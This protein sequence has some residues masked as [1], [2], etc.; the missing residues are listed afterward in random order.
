MDKEL[1]DLSANIINQHLQSIFE[2]LP[3]SII[4]TNIDGKIEYV[5]LQFSNLTGYTFEESIG[6]NPR[7]LKSKNTSKKVYTNLWETILSGKS[8]KGEIQNIKKHG[9]GYWVKVE[10]IP[11]KDKEGKITH[12]FSIEEDITDFVEHK[13]ELESKAYFDDLTGLANRTL[14]LDRIEQVL[15]K[16]SRNETNMVL[17]FIDLDKFKEVNDI[18]GHEAGDALLLE[19]AYRFTACVRNS[20]TVARLGGDEFLIILP[21]LK[22]VKVASTVAQRILNAFHKPFVFSNETKQISPSIG[23]ALY[24]DDGQD[25]ETLLKNSDA[26]MY[27]AKAKGRNN[28]QFFTEEMNREVILRQGLEKYFKQALESQEIGACY[29]PVV[30]S[31]SKKI[32]G[33]E[34]FPYWENP[35]FGRLP[36][37]RILQLADDTG[38]IMPL[39]ESIFNIACQKIQ[40]LRDIIGKTLIIYLDVS[41]QKLITD[42]KFIST[43]TKILAQ[44]KIDMDNL[45]LGFNVSLFEEVMGKNMM[46]IVENVSKEGIKC[47]IYNFGLNSFV[48]ENINMKV[49][50]CLRLHSNIFKESIINIEYEAL[51]PAIILFA[52]KLGL[53]VIVKDVNTA[54]QHEILRGYGCDFIQGLYISNPLNDKD[55]EAFLEIQK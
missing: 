28:F 8:W 15:V 21:E 52:Q 26:A 43:F 17:M 42:K 36:S 31:W 47:S 24:P 49:F 29:Q 14:A 23:L 33:V 13:K 41:F 6:K 5:N 25:S 20:D 12:F 54:Q 16:A 10:I 53:L 51:M 37:E 50:K 19:A 39:I 27:R 35:E 7:F 22:G 40:L 9:E 55:F 3:Y 46:N 4:L 45:Y 1:T 11:L 34:I 38:L 32:I 44:Y 2:K 30:D 48:F 18:H